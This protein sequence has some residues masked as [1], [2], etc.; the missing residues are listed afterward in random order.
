M[1]AFAR[2]AFFYLI[3]A[4]AAITLN[5]IL[6]RIMPGDP[7]TAMLNK[8]RGG[9]ALSPNAV[10]ALRKLFGQN[11][12]NLWHQYVEYWGKLFH[13]DLGVSVTDYP[14]SVWSVII[15]GAPWT[16][17]LIGLST[18]LS[19]LLGTALGVFV[20]WKRGTWLDAFVPVTNFISA[21][22]YFWFALIAVYV[23]ATQLHWFPI[24]QAYGLGMQ[25]GFTGSFIGSALYHGVL[26]ALTIVVSSIGGWL[27]GMRNMMVTTLSEDYVL[28]AEAKGLAKRRIIFSY[29]ARNAMLPSLAGFAMS[30]GFVIGGSIVTEV[31][32][33]YPGLGYTLFSAVQNQD[34]PL[35]Q[36][37]FLFLIVTVLLANLAVDFLYVLLDPRTRQEA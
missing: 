30:L 22:P 20:G 19:F 4:W 37:C 33:S 8:M 3:A 1:R 24:N 16:L 13:G 28:L 14:N 18:V 6:P 12:G 36:G 27:L 15:Q 17:V 10:F 29:A 23:L 21:I 34:Y 5:F 26:P 9:L 25:P 35:M 7:V 2:R 32:F 31:V 11:D